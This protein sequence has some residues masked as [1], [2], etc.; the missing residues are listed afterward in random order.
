[1]RQRNIKIRIIIIAILS[2]S[3]LL[4]GQIDSI[5]EIIIRIPVSNKKAISSLD[6]YFLRENYINDSLKI[7]IPST[8][9]D[10]FKSRFPG[11]VV[12]PSLPKID[13]SDMA[14]T[15]EEAML[16]TKYPNYEQYDSIMHYFA[17]SFPDI[18]EIDTI[19][20]S[21]QGRL[22]LALKISD[23]VSVQEDEPSFFYSATIH[24]DELV[25]YMLTM[26]LI[27]FILENYGSNIEIDRIVN[28]LEIWINPLSNPDG[29]Y[30]G[31][32][33][34]VVSSIR[35]NS[36]GFDLNRNYPDPLG[37]DADDTS[38]VQ[39]ENQH[40]MLFM[41]EKK[42]NLSA[43]IHSGAE[44]VNY[45]WDHI[46]DRHADNEWFIFISE[47]YAD[48]AR[49]VN[50][51]YM[52]DFVDKT[53][54]ITG[55]TNGFDW[56]DITGGRQDYVT[57]YLH[58]RELT[59]ELSNVKKLESEHF[60]N[61]WSYNKWSMINLISQ[62][63]YGIHGN[64]R[65]KNTGLPLNAKIWVLN[66]D[67]ESSWIESDSLSGYFYRYLKEGIYDLVIS[68]DGYFNDTLISIEVFDYQKTELSVELIDTTSY[69]NAIYYNAKFQI[70][71]N[72][73]SDHVYLKS[74][75]L[76]NPESKIIFYTSD[77]KIVKN[78]YQ[79]PAVKAIK[80][81]VSTLNCGYYFIHIIDAKRTIVLPLI[82]Q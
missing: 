29:T 39:K 16:F 76:L 22:I 58:G 81:D 59:L 30:Q 21:I 44:V 42:F 60:D 40:M 14:S 5:N 75:H 71:P 47:E 64:V 41:R 77:G 62:A 68:K 25:G 31:G 11:L 18:C 65:N 66:H 36:N 79:I 73:A 61:F 38:G 4:F 43:N 50:S 34:T 20:K 1:V 35:G 32:N 2:Q 7:S 23:N 26:R 19:G 51:N 48:E 46:V 49:A 67:S 27:H 10:Q 82:I 24:G 53:S 80:I 9:L 78:I 45:P 33:N 72:P 55:I 69:T 13:A 8:D 54:G 57:Y 70:Y 12:L 63:R 52:N 28:D 74:E 6:Y 56:Y 3:F 37:N 15:F 17:A